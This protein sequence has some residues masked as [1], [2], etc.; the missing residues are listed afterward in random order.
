MRD[1]ADGQIE[2]QAALTPEG[3]RRTTAAWIAG[4]C[5]V[6]AAST[7]VIEQGL[8]AL[9]FQLGWRDLTVGQ[10]IMAGAMFGVLLE[11]K[12]TVLNVIPRVITVALMILIARHFGIGASEC[13]NVEYLICSASPAAPVIAKGAP[14]FGFWCGV[15]VWRLRKRFGSAAN[16][17]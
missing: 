16:Q 15:E 9:G 17:A 12:H 7:L 14:F 3:S 5:G 1:H 4:A 10:C 8:T 2:T 13:A 6:A 11:G